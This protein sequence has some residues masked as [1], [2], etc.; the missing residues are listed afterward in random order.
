MKI[1]QL[2][3]VALGVAALMLGQTPDGQL[4]WTQA[5]AQVRPDVGK[6]LKAASDLLKAGKGAEALAKVRE[7]E[8]VSGR[9]ADENA[10]L[11]GMRVAAASRAGDADQMV[12]GYE[13][14]KGMGRL[15]SAQQLQMM[16]SIAGTYSRSNQ[17]AKA[18]DWANK[19][20]AAGGNSPS[21]KQ[22]QSYSQWNSGDVG[23]V[24]KDTLAEIQADEKAGRAPSQQKLNLLLSAAG[25]KGDKATEALAVE[26][27]LTYYPTKQLWNQV[28]GTLPSKKGF[29]P[30]FQLDIY[31][32][33]LATEN[34]RDANDYME[35]AQIAAQAGFPEEGKRVMDQGYA[36]KALGQGA[37]AARQ[38][39]LADLLVTRIAE[40]KSAQAQAEAEARASKEGDALVKLGLASAFRGQKTEAVKLVEDGIAK[41]AF[42]RPDDVRLYQG[43]AYYTVGDN[44]KAIA[45]WRAV[46]GSDG[47][48]DIARLYAQLAR[49]KR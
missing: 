45:A 30:R 11:E 43:L 3:A 22:V 8:G 20:F 36:A 21:M 10:A 9:N 24:L 42:K 6:H 48:A 16:E 25:K 5:Q 34:L 41:G 7:A 49:S 12:K 33:R 4:G 13:A 1:K 28:L 14:L 23:G 39:R 2:A 40:A 15:P 26:K 46:K 18:L 31:R 47:S 29:S 19:Y 17:H 35:M 44:A 27:L 37:E 32:L 38:K